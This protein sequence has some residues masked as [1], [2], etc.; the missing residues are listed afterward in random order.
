MTEAVINNG[1]ARNSTCLDLLKHLASL[2]FQFNF[3]ISASYIPG[4]ENIMADIIS[5]LHEPRKSNLLAILF[6]LPLTYAM[7]YGDIT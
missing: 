5:R 7:A 4:L 2:A 3:T 6:N 1:T